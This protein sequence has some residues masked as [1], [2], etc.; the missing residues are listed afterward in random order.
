[1]KKEKKANW[2]FTFGSGQP[3]AGCYIKF[4]GICEETRKRMFDA[5]GK[6]W[7][8]QYSEKQWNNPSPNSSKFQGLDPKTKP[9]MAEVW[10]WKEIS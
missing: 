5:F 4:F 10:G 7:S 8:I 3:H 9:T 2:Y 6:V 1:M